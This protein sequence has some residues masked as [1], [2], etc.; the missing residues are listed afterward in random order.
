M[1]FWMDQVSRGWLIYELT[2]S[3]VQLGLVRG[4]QAIPILLLSPIAGSAADRYSRKTQILVAQIIDGV[5]FAALALL[6]FTGRNST[7]A[8][9]RDGVRHGVCADLSAAGAR[10][11]HRRRRADRESHQRHRPQLDHLQR[12]PKHRAGAGRRA[13]RRGWAP[14]APIGTQAVFY[15]LATYWTLRLRARRAIRVSWRGG[16]G[17]SDSFAQEHRRRLEVQLAQPGT[18]APRLLVTMFASLFIVPFTTLLPV[19]ARDI[20]DVGATGQGLLLTA[21]GIGALGSAMMIATFGDRMPRGLFMLGGVGAVRCRR[22]RIRGIALVSSVHRADGR[23][24]VSPTSART[25]W[26]RP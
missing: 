21:M 22:R 24:S 2:D 20:L 11:D 6:I 16:H 18:C 10:R 13:H 26:C 12:R 23:S 4:V 7:L 3:T 5:M 8:R 15:F 1:A 9:L 17:H 25:R 14:A 19:F